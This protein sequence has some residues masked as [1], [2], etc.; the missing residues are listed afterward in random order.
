MATSSNM[1]TTNSNIWY[2]IEMI[3]NSQDVANNTSNVTVRVWFE[4]TAGYTSYGTGTVYCKINGTQYSASVTTSQK[5]TGTPIKLFEKTLNIGHNTDGT[6]SLGMSAWISHSVVDSNEQSWSSSLS[7]IAR[8][9]V[10]TMSDTTVDMGVAVT[11]YTNRASPSFTHTISYTFGSS[12]GTI[13]TANGVG[14]SVSWTPAVTLASQ[15]PNATSGSGA[16]TCKTYNGTTLIGTKTVNFTLYVPSSVVPTFTAVTASENV[17]AVTT[18][19][20]GAYVQGVSKVNLAI[21]GA[22]GVHSS[23]ITSYSITFDG[24]SYSTASA[25]SGVIKGTGTLTITG[26]ITDSRGRTATKTLNITSLAYSAPKITTFTVSRCNSDGT[27]NP[28]GTYAKVTRI[29]TTTNL[30]S[31]NNFT[32][33]VYSKDRAVATFTSKETASSALGTVSMNDTDIFSTYDII[34]S[35]DF[36]LELKDKLTTTPVTS[37]VVLSTGSVTMS[38]GKDGIGVGKVWENG[39]LDVTGDTYLNG[40][41][42]LGSGYYITGNRLRPE[43]IVANTD[44]N[45]IQ[46]VGFYYCPLSADAGTMLNKPT[47]SAFSLRVE[48][49]AGRRQILTEYMTSG[50]KE[51]S[52]N[53]YSGTW[54]EWILTGGDPQPATASLASGWT[55]YNSTGWSIP[56]YYKTASDEVRIQGMVA[57]G[58]VGSTIFTLPVGYRPYRNEIFACAN[59][60]STTWEYS[61][62]YV[63][64]ADGR[65]TWADGGTSGW[66]S[67]SGIIFKAGG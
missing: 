65:V 53:M 10:P 30:N 20:I 25:I 46:D 13:G 66:I 16:I 51:F 3:Q 42:W 55:A 57:G 64:S 54:G 47:S 7:T 1:T 8:A 22:S 26:K 12:T 37:N 58:T 23:T 61:R 28:L 63:Y 33:T 45:T 35:Y 31:K 5:I 15:I 59:G 32:Y 62:V 29:G 38:W 14:T 17:T 39:A 21:T 19:G 60:D 18:A 41:V 4:R 40:N 67:L 11:I 2:W 56:G 34:T 44:L 36:K 6:K 52:R 48:H 49:H 50:W 9:S 24:S 43:R 27:A